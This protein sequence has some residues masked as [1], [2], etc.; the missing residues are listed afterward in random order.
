M[1][2]LEV[3]NPTFLLLLTYYYTLK[4]SGILNL[5]QELGGKNIT[6]RYAHLLD[7]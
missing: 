1:S 2:P 7:N 5:A 3:D 4:Y 6:Q